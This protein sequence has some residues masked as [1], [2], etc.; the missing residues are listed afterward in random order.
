MTDPVR[1]YVRAVTAG[2]IVAGPGVRAACQRHLDDLR[3]GPGRGLRWDQDKA[4]R[5]LDFFPE[6]LRLAEGAF[7]GKPFVLSPFQQFIVGSLFGWIGADGFRRYRMAYLEIGKGSGKTTTAA[8]VGLYML[9]ADHEESAEVYA[10]ATTKDQAQ[11]AFRDAARMVAASP[12]LAARIVASGVQPVYNLAH[13]APAR[14]FARSR[15]RVGRST[16]SGRMA[17]SWTSFMNTIRRLCSRS[18]RPASRAAGSR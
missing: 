5:A 16:A 4:L 14:S 12:E 15:P 18:F 8:G 3:H 6:V 2:A 9:T 7:A 11:I 1:D 17:S 13:L 10:A